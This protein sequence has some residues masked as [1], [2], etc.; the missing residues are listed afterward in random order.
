MIKQ[1]S[2]RTTLKREVEQWL[3]EQGISFEEITMET[4]CEMIQAVS[5]SNDSLEPSY[6]ELIDIENDASRVED[7]SYEIESIIE[8]INNRF[9]LEDDLD[10][11][12]EKILD[13]A[14]S[15]R[16]SSNNIELGVDMVRSELR[17]LS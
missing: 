5:I 12:I 2:H 17:K 11:M 10:I 13:S 9:K 4:L 6:D 8:K 14:K 1:T 16:S 7:V 15:L 3:A